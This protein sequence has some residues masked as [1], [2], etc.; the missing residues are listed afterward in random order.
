M[1][2]LVNPELLEAIEEDDIKDDQQLN[3]LTD[4]EIEFLKLC[5]SEFTYK[6]IAEEMNVSPRTIDG[7]RDILLEKLK[8]K[9]RIGLALYAMKRNLITF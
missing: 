7:Y 6:E 4:R 9:S 3:H 5:A 1:N 2:G 8:A